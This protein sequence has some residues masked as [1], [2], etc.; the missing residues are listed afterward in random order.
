M[1]SWY[2]SNNSGYSTAPEDMLDLVQD[3]IGTDAREVG[4]V[5]RLLGRR[6]MDGH[7]HDPAVRR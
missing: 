6:G 3:W 7:G 2:R 5:G 4:E 1:Q